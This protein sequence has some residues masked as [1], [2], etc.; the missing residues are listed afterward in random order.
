MTSNKVA[1]EPVAAE[2]KNP[3]LS[4]KESLHSKGHQSTMAKG[5]PKVSSTAG[6]LKP[7]KLSNVSTQQVSKPTTTAKTAKESAKK[8]S[9]EKS[10]DAKS[11]SKAS[12]AV[13]EESSTL[14]AKPTVSDKPAGKAPKVKT[15]A[16]T[17]LP[18]RFKFHPNDNSDGILMKALDNMS[19]DF[20]CS[21]LEKLCSGSNP[22]AKVLKKLFKVPKKKTENWKDR[23]V[24]RLTDEKNGASDGLKQELLVRKE[25]VV[26]WEDGDD[27]NR[28]SRK[29]V[30]KSSNHGDAAK[31]GAAS[32]STADGK[33]FTAR[34]SSCHKCQEFYDVTKNDVGMCKY[35]PGRQF[36]PL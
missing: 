8:P 2:T 3:R 20:F 31:S 9:T 22:L 5:L 18:A 23:V 19:P 6:P 36:L 13:R 34:F 29:K 35:H 17:P 1:K 12:S 7:Q 16:A 21:I 30:D 14:K 26:I 25:D 10:G 27:K 24:E 33:S 32:C 4:G 11:S 28:Y 15:I